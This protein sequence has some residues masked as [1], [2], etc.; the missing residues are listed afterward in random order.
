MHTGTPSQSQ[1]RRGTLGI[2][3][4]LACQDIRYEG[5]VYQAVRL[6]YNKLSTHKFIPTG[7]HSPVLQHES[8]LNLHCNL[9]ACVHLIRDL[10]NGRLGLFVCVA[11][12][13]LK[14]IG[15]IAQ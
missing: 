15:T 9:A 4:G 14:K 2:K 1:N 8:A 13:T 5:L 6:R 11:P 12:V 10:V 7:A 3:A